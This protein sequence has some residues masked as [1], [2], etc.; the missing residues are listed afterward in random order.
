MALA[1]DSAFTNGADRVAIIGADCPGLTSEVMAKAFSLLTSHDLVLGPAN[2]GGYYLVGLTRPCSR[3]FAHIPWGADAVLGET[4]DA[5]RELGMAFA[6]LEPLDDVDRPGDLD[7]WY[8]ASAAAGRPDISVVI[9]ALNEAERIQTAVEPV[10]AVPGVEVIVADGGSRDGAQ[11]IASASGA[12]VVEAPK[13]RGRQMN[14][15]AA[16]AQGS[17]LLFLHADTALPVQWVKD[18]RETLADPGT[19]AG[20]FQLRF[21]ANLPGL[22]LVERL[23]NFRSRRF[24]TPYGDQAIFLRSETFRALGGFPDIP[25][26]EDFEFVRRLRRM[27]NIRI[28]PRAVTTSARRWK[29]NGVC[30]TTLIHQLI[31]MAYLAGISPRFIA[32]LAAR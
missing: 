3:L 6:L 32:R 12:K 21:D 11:E 19:A 30:T 20:A 1:F 25:I 26:M 10:L 15:G 2:D 8:R 24:Q 27:G 13:G 28:V 9:P 31:I 22:R 16:I 18:V 4:L 14:A 5:A 7:V 17:V 29:N 23:A